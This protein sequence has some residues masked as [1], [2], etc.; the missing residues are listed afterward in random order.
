ML[1][2]FG[3][4]G[5]PSEH[6]SVKIWSAGRY[7]ILNRDRGGGYPD[8]GLSDITLAWM[9]SQIQPF[10]DFHHEYILE[11]YDLTEEHYEQT[12]QTPRPWSLGKIYRSMTGIYVVGGRLTRTPGRYCRVD[13]ETGESTGKPLRQTNEYIHPSARSRTVLKGPGT[14]D[15][16]LY[17]SHALE[18]YKVKSEEGPD[19]R[20]VTFWQPRGRRKSSKLKDLHEAPLLRTER[21]LLAESPRTEEYLYGGPPGGPPGPRVGSP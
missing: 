10:I 6:V 9:L 13:P 21:E 18:G 5:S 12:D 20:P 14:E 19:Q 15:D 7:S 16:G 17:H 2:Q 8:Q 3:L 1:T 11:Q 4:K